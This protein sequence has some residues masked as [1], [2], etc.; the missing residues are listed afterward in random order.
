MVIRRE[1]RVS[2]VLREDESLI[3]VFVSLS[4]AFERLRNRAMRKVMSRLVTVEQAARVAGLD[5]DELVA[6]LNARG[7]AGDGAPEP[8]NARDGLEATPV[9]AVTAASPEL[10]A[11]LR[12]IP[13]DRVVDLDVREELRNGREPFSRIMAASRETPPGGALRVRAIFEPVPLYAVMAKQG[14]AHHTERLGTE[15]WRVWFYPYDDA[16]APE[17]PA[18]GH[19]PG[20]VAVAGHAGE[21]DSANEA[22]GDVVVLDV[23]G[24]EPPEPMV[25]TL[26]ALE[27]LPA[28]ATL[29]QIN[30]RVP[31]FLLPLLGERGFAYEIREQE[32]DLVRVFIRRAPAE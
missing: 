27:S 25:R 28:D 32:P 13:P 11:R 31:Q 17:A 26:V 16:G 10:P 3:D 20:S 24:L 6:R 8:A 21:A 18:R 29:V 12:S 22:E 2:A 14:L 15:D 5:A 19:V 9:A 7:R 23:R 30:V 4:P 1:D